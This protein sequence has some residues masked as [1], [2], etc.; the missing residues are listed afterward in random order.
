MLTSLH[1]T[2]TCFGLHLLS[3]GKEWGIDMLRNGGKEKASREMEGE[4]G[5]GRYRGRGGGSLHIR[6]HACGE[7]YG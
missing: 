5:G 6:Q 3:K 2:G 7:S 4:M 1:S